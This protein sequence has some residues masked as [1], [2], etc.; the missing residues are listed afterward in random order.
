M[1]TAV[2]AP[3]G[4]TPTR[5]TPRVAPSDRRPP[6]SAVEVTS[7]EWALVRECTGLL[8]DGRSGQTAYRRS[9]HALTRALADM[10]ALRLD[11]EAELHALIGQDASGRSAKALLPV[12]R[13]VHNGRPLSPTQAHAADE[14]GLESLNAWRQ[15]QGRAESELG[16]VIDSRADAIVAARRALAQVASLEPVVKA[17]AA[18]SLLLA[19]AVLRYA[20]RAGAVDRRSVKS[21]PGVLR[22]V[23]RASTKT[24]PLGWF[25]RVG[26]ADRSGPCPELSVDRSIARPPLGELRAL[27]LHL[28]AQRPADERMLRLAPD[29]DVDEDSLGFTRRGIAGDQAVRLR[30][31]A[32]LDAAVA[33]FD[34]GR[35]SLTRAQARELLAVS[36]DTLGVL[37]GSGLVVPADPLPEVAVAHTGQL[38]QWCAGV[39][40]RDVAGPLEELDRLLVRYAASPHHRRTDLGESAERVWRTLPGLA[41]GRLVLTEDLVGGIGTA[42]L[43][44]RP[45]LEQL[46][47]VCQ[48]FDWFSIVRRVQAVRFVREFGAGATVSNVVR[49]A[50]HYDRTWSNPRLLEDPQ[51]AADPVVCRVLKCRADIAA[52]ATFLTVSPGLVDVDLGPEAIHAA[53]VGLPRELGARPYSIS[54]FVQQTDDGQ[55]VNDVYGGWGRFTSRFLDQLPGSASAAVQRDMSIGLGESGQ[56][57]QVRPVVGFAANLHPLLAPL[58]ISDDPGA[59]ECL[60]L[61]D[62]EVIH[63]IVDD[64]VRIR[65]RG[66]DTALDVIYLGFLVPLLLPKRLRPVVNDLG[67]GLVDFAPLRQQVELST[68]VGPCSA[69]GRLTAGTTVL[70]RRTWELGADQVSQLLRLLADPAVPGELTVSRLRVALGWPSDV[71]IGGS[72]AGPGAG[73][74][75]TAAFTERMGN[76]RSQ[77]VDLLDPLH[78]LALPRLLARFPHGIRVEEALPAPRPGEPARECVVETYRKASSPCTPS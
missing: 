37:E 60:H 38:A 50:N 57:A 6:R 32:A 63:D 59:G 48:A 73:L 70:G 56:A 54:F 41:Q 75:G 3:A 47:T 49:Y 53:S 17:A 66:S 76:D 11:V 20:A 58:E 67:S 25:V 10:E 43:V 23:L 19:Q 35:R 12:R 13:S 64:E 16:H 40:A 65:R 22:H 34:G 29:L 31:S 4:V 33:A 15:A 1:L 55:V 77:Y 72:A 46:T 61:A 2:A 42:P 71:F 78:L 24:V 44:D 39:G 45:S 69:W 52:A 18:T 36:S 5:P 62:L 27:L 68:P 9:S 26:W 8:P 14:V 7:T 30:R 74:P 21:E 51:V 28:D